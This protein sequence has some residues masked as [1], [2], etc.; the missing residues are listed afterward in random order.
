VIRSK[1]V[2]KRPSGRAS[3]HGSEEMVNRVRDWQQ[4]EAPPGGPAACCHC[5]S[6]R[7]RTHAPE[8]CGHQQ[9][10]AD[11]VAG[12]Q[13]SEEDVG[14][15]DATVHGLVLPAAVPHQHQEHDVLKHKQG[16]AHNQ[17]P[18]E[19]EPAAGWVIRVAGG[20]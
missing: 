14:A 19:L 17:R 16:C 6:T 12:R 4:E 7:T 11:P 18:E 10:D 2:A 20:E 5:S 9:Q 13:V 8:A 15:Q 3:E 1:Q